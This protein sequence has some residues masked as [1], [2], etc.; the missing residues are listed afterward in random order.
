[1][2]IGTLVGSISA[3]SINRTLARSLSVM[4]GERAEVVDITI[5]DL[6]LYN[7]TSTRRRPPPSD[8]SSHPCSTSTGC[9][10]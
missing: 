1:M 9:S 3:D 10:S 6:P 2:K 8:A 5:G 7:R 4:I